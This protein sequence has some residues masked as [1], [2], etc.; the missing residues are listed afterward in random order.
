[1]GQVGDLPVDSFR[2]GKYSGEEASGY[3]AGIDAEIRKR[4]EMKIEALR[5][6]LLIY[7]QFKF[8]KNMD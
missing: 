3:L 6:I 1:M 2:A 5:T 7:I 4:G 8:T